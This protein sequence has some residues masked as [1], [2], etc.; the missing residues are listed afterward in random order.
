M[1]ENEKIITLIGSIKEYLITIRRKIHKYPELGFKEFITTDLVKRELSKHDISI[2]ETG[3]STGL[4]AVIQG[5]KKGKSSVIAI[6]ADID[7][8]P[9]EEETGLAY[10]SENLGVMHACGHDGHTAILMGTAIVL[11]KLTKYF[12]G[13]IKFIFQPSEESLTGAKYMIKAG[14]LDNPRV[15]KIIALHSWPYLE[16]GVIGKWIGPYYASADSFEISIIGESGHGAYPHKTP[17]SIIAAS[18]IVCNL[19]NIISRQIEAIDN[20]VL[21]VC[22]ISGGTT[23]NVMPKKTLIK[24]TVRSIKSV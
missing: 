19:Q 16:T 14:V 7:A 4:L 22:M 1:D 8:L 21:S 17:D 23:F 18:N 15:E 6:R 11:S 2:V 10:A 12:S 20:V 13:T 5:K 24:G 9:I 3:V